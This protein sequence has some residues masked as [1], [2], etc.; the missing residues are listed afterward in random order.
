MA[1][2]AIDVQWSASSLNALGQLG[3][4]DM[5]LSPE[6]NHF[7]L[8]LIRCPSKIHSELLLQISDDFENSYSFKC[9]LRL[10]IQRLLSNLL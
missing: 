6:T 5:L 4:D 7:D 1:Y 10:H 8:T 9:M 3:K 2:S